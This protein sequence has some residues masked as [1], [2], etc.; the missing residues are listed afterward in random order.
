MRTTIQDLN[1]TGYRP[2]GVSC[3]LSLR[4]RC[5]KDR[6]QLADMLVGTCKKITNI[7]VLQGKAE[8]PQILN[9]GPGSPKTGWMTHEALPLKWRERRQE[10]MLHEGVQ[11]P[12]SLQETRRPRAMCAVR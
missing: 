3:L 2:Q 10:Q 6:N 9:G 1:R 11:E 7:R 5:P 12:R 4:V 8:S